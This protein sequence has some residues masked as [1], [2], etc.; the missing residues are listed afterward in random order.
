MRCLP[1]VLAAALAGAASVHA[2]TA[3][4]DRGRPL[5]LQG[6][7]GHQAE[8]AAFETF[9]AQQ[10][11]AGIVPTYQLLR[12]A[13]MWRE[14]QAS[15]FQVPPAAQWPMVRDVLLLLQELQR[16]KVLGPFAVASAYRDPALNR[17]AHGSKHSSHMQFAVDLVPL[18]PTDDQKLCTFWRA[19]GKAWN[20]GLSRYPSGRIHVDRTGWRTW[21]EDYTLR[22]SYC[23][24]LAQK[25]P[26]VS[27]FTRVGRQ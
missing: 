26:Q 9:L 1:F 20:M 25:R 18:A 24:Q 6:G 4:D 27:G 16:T 3:D 7:P 13:S 11:V 14:C 17:C 19:Q 22:S 10:K 15:P 2:Q 8:V 12:S 5:F 23:N 21:G